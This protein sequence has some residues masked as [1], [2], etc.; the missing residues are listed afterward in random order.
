M[1]RSIRTGL[2]SVTFRRMNAAAIAQLAASA[3]LEC[4]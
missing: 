1:S 3:G 4:I 2:L